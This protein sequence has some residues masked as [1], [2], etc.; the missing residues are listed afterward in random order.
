M[1]RL[2]AFGLALLMLALTACAG[3][4]STDAPAAAA[5]AGPEYTQ[6]AAE[7]Q[8][9]PAESSNMGD[10]SMPLD[11]TEPADLD[12]VPDDSF[13]LSDGRFLSAMMN[14]GAARH[15]LSLPVPVLI[16]YK[17]LRKQEKAKQ[18]SDTIIQRENIVSAFL[19]I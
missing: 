18:Y 8:Q 17:Y 11:E 4:G 6:S 3:S 2:M 13:N 16:W 10:G 19:K 12:A 1:R 7:D 5:S 14:A 9:S 15:T